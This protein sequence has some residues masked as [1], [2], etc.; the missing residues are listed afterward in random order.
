M[1]EYRKNKGKQKNK[2]TQTVKD[3]I[4]KFIDDKDTAFFQL[5]YDGVTR[6]SSSKKPARATIRLPDYI[7]GTDTRDLRKW[8][9]VC[10]AIPIEKIMELIEE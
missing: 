3:I 9:I 4:K 10:I 7:C 1:T 2:K 5:I 6:A 8:Q